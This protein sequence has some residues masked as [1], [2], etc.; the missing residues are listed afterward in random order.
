MT[1]K[2]SFIVFSIVT[3]LNKGAALLYFPLLISFLSI[4]DYG[5][6]TLCFLAANVCAPLFA[7]GGVASVLRESSEKHDNRSMS[8]L[9]IYSIC[10]FFIFTA[11]YL[12]YEALFLEHL[13]WVKYAFIYGECL[14]VLAL[15]SSY[16]RGKNQVV[17]YGVTNLLPV[18]LLFIVMLVS[19]SNSQDIVGLFTFQVYSYSLA[20]FLS[21]L[22][23]VVLNHGELKKLKQSSLDELQ[24]K[25]SF[26]FSISLLPHNISQWL[27]SSSDRYIISALIGVKAV[28]VYSIAYNLAQVLMLVNSGLALTVQP[29]LIRNYKAWVDN[30][31]S[32]KF[33]S[34]YTIVA[35]FLFFALCSFIALDGNYNFLSIDYGSDLYFVFFFVYISL[36]FLGAY[37]FFVNFLFYH[38][39][40][41]EISKV[42]ILVCFLNVTLSYFMASQV[43]LVGVAIANL[44][45]YLVYLLITKSKALKVDANAHFSLFKTSVLFILIMFTVF[46]SFISFWWV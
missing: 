46:C 6:W 19:K 41:N 30:N 34:L 11:I 37:Y 29:F 28:G 25:R 26:S 15:L 9:I 42:T 36:Y 17:L 21:V 24:I 1:I 18:L 10:S 14:A 4:E 23:F 16:Y 32:D 22:I 43:G 38:K 12:I 20:A 13:I 45:S 27:L 31:Y 8:L 7:L 40:G 33:F 5:I 44:F 39:K 2:N 35:A 3:A